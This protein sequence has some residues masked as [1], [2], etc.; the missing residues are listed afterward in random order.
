MQNE[1][2]K[3]AA[4]VA[5]APAAA[6]PAPVK[7]DKPRKPRIAKPAPAPAIETKPDA[8]AIAARIASERKL[9]TDLFTKLSQS[10]SIP[11]KPLSAFRK[12]YKKTIIAAPN[13]ANPTPRRAAAVYIAMLASGA[14]LANGSKFPRIFK[15]AGADYC[16][17][18]GAITR[19]TESGLISYD[20][21]TEIV[22]IK[23][24]ADISAQ[25]KTAG[26]KL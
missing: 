18:N 2:T 16:L 3:P 13:G 10:V 11:I 15:L 12:Q 21:A 19:C 7:A 23:S 24:A 1:N 5:P 8:Q 20:S 9:A 22:T 17:D 25:I 26:F 14:K 4:I 6:K